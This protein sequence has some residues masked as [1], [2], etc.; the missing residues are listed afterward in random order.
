MK[1]E[2]ERAK[3]AAQVAQAAANASEQKFP[4]LG[5]KETKVYLTNELD[6]V[7]RN[8]CLEVWTEALNLTGV[9]LPRSGRELRM[10]TIHKTSKELLKLTRVF[11]QTLVDSI[12]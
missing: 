1:A 11:A 3:E 2:L 7:C 10:F 12:F 9:L 6:G 5:G 4:N 8:Y